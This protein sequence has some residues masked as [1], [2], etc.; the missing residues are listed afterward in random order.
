MQ[1][2]IHKLLNKLRDKQIIFEYIP[3]HVGIE[4][5]ELADRA[6]KEALGDRFLIRLPYNVDEFSCLI[7]KKVRVAWQS[8]WNRTPCE[9]R[10]LKPVLGDWKSA[11]RE[12]RREEVV[13]SRLR[14]DC[15]YYFV[16]HH[17]P[18]GGPPQNRCERCHVYN[19]IKHLIIDCPQWVNY[20]RGMISYLNRKGLNLSM[21]NVLGDDF[22]HK[23][24]FTYLR[25]IKYYD[26][27]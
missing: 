4:G 17:F 14:T 25:D 12:C 1:V 6:A 26:K 24:L 27:I 19:S 16:Q 3:S 23:I 8:E 18:W 9:Y 7:K 13:L 2:R 15:G 10:S 5:N 11:Y 22:N 20:R 21:E